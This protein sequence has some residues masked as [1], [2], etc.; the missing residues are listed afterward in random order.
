MIFGAIKKLFLGILLCIAHDI[1]HTPSDR[2][3][4]FLG[5]AGLEGYSRWRPLPFRRRAFLIRLVIAL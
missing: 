1:D 2:E 4:N 3:Q 5:I